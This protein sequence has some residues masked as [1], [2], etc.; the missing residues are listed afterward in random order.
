MTQSRGKRRTVMV[1]ASAYRTAML[2]AVLVLATF[3][4]PGALLAQEP[5]RPID[6]QAIFDRLEAQDAEIARLRAQ[7]TGIEE[8]GPA[9]I[10]PVTLPAP[11]VSIADVAGEATVQPQPASFTIEQFEDMVHRV[12]SLEQAGK[13]KVDSEKKADDGW[14]DVSSEKWTIKL[15]GH[16]QGDY[17][18]W[19]RADPAIE[20]ASGPDTQDYFEFRRLRL[21]AD[22]IGYG[23]YDF[24]FQFDIEPEAE[25]D[26]GVNTPVTVVKDAYLTIQETEYLGRVRFGNFFV[27]FSL[28]QVTNDTN[29]IFMERSIP[30]QGIFAA[31][32]EVGVAS[33]NW[34]DDKNVSWTYGVF[35]D[36]ISESL[37]ERIDDNQGYRVSGRVTWL[38]YYDEPSNGRYLVHTGAGI[39]FTDEQD[40][41]AQFRARPQIH[42]G[43]RLID[44]GVLPAAS[45]TTGNVELATVL[46][47][48]SVQTEWFLC[49][50]NLD[51]GGPTTLYGG[52]IYASYFLTGENRIYE[53]E[54]QHGA[55]FGRSVPYTNFF[56]VPGCH[57]C[58]AWEA[59]ARMSYLNLDE[60]DAGRYH[61]L[62]VGFNWYWTERIRVMF[63][64]IHPMTSEETTF[65]KTDSDLLATRLDFNF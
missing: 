40:D 50:V 57:G 21:L 8:L 31:N 13:K 65:G 24:R 33:Y 18:N 52:Y 42:E 48:L 41:Q 49:S 34:S 19:V 16:V 14:K 26:D 55:Q 63:D 7:L 59:K 17:I 61:D 9:A 5:M 35:F 30:T 29:N 38:P 44:S 3:V 28:E 36:S 32:R 20:P 25:A 2:S 39:L 37:K 6:A 58:G 12:E 4:A 11:A 53:R 47:P 56:C 54:G 46:G 10:K 45:T 23:V 60:V 62:T 1:H 22:G 27:P 15:G 51:D 43:P 64:W